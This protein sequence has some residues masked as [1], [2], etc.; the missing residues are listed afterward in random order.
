MELVHKAFLK[1]QEI[2]RLCMLKSLSANS[3]IFICAI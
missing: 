3:G 2:T 1:N